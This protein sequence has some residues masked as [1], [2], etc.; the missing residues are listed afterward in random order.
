MLCAGIAA[1]G[2]AE[3]RNEREQVRFAQDGRRV[4]LAALEAGARLE[5]QLG[6]V[7]VGLAHVRDQLR[8]QQVVEPV[9]HVD[10]RVLRVLAAQST[11]NSQL[12][13][14]HPVRLHLQNHSM[15]I[16]DC[17]THITGKQQTQQGNVLVET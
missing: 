12:T 14:V 9:A 8:L 11:G 15:K 6:R 2:L 10:R 1:V 3:A 16:A 17:R 7:H 4:P 5:V 13:S